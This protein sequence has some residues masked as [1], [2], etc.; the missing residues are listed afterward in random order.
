MALSPDHLAALIDLRVAEL[1]L[2]A[3]RTAVEYWHARPTLAERRFL[4]LA[5][6][7]EPPRPTKGWP[8]KIT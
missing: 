5:R 4:A 3:A 8:P 6:H 7:G 1:R 2:L